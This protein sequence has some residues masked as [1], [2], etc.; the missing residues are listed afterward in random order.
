MKRQLDQRV[1]YLKVA[2]TIWKR[3]NVGWF[4]FVNNGTASR[5][6]CARP[7]S[8]SPQLTLI[9]RQIVSAVLLTAFSQLVA[10]AQDSCRH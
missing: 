2:F 4:V 6:L 10:C 9:N 8:Y 7:P 5:K 3:R 1:A